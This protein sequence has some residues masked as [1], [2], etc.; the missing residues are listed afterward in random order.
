MTNYGQQ[1]RDLRGAA[2]I[3]QRALSERAGITQSNLCESEKGNRSMTE[4]EFFRCRAAISDL[5]AERTAAYEEACRGL[6]S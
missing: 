5:V 1:V 6:A 3:A 2:G 4:G